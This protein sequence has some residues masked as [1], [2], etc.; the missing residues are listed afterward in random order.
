[1]QGRSYSVLPHTQLSFFLKDLFVLER[2]RERV[3][4]RAGGGVEGEKE[5][6]NL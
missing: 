5:G 3:S 4:E 1:M 6:E 2:E